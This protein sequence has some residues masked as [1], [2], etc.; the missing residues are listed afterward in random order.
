MD[1]DRSTLVYIYIYIFIYIYYIYIIYLYVYI[2]SLGPD[3]RSPKPLFFLFC[4]CR[5][6]KKEGYVK[7]G[8]G[9]RTL[10]LPLSVVAVTVLTV[11]TVLTVRDSFDLIPHKESN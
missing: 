11:L 10:D 4:I 2:Y 9:K 5:M 6:N 7:G 1:I 3:L 8:K